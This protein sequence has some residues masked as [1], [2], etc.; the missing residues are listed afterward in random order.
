MA[1]DNASLISLL[2]N[3]G[4]SLWLYRTTDT[5]AAVLSPGYFSGAASRLQTGDVIL[6]QAADALTLT[7]VRPNL[8]VPAGLVVD[9]AAVPFRVNR[10][11]AQ[12]FSVQQAA[13]ALAMTLL[14]GPLAGGITAG[15]IINARASVGGP[16]AQVAFSV[17]DAAGS[18]VRGPQTANVASGAANAS[19]DAPATGT[20]YRL[21]VEAVGNPAIADTSPSFGVSPAYAV[22]QQNG[23]TLLLQDGGR[24]L[25]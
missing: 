24:L 23:G 3:S 6:L 18:T 16:I 21:R 1:F 9:T 4:F 20:G 22:L 2:S 7:T 17:R 25:V 8:V 5:R 10:T 12:G 13:T 14:L 15:S 19:L 11:A